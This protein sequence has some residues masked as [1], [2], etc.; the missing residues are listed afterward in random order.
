MRLKSS[1]VLRLNSRLVAWGLREATAWRIGERRANGTGARRGERQES[2]DQ[3]GSEPGYAQLLCFAA[4]ISRSH[5]PRA[6]G[7]DLD[8]GRGRTEPAWHLVPGELDAL[9]SCSYSSDAPES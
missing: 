2:Q 8:G 3:A 4:L 1:Q 6:W 9:H 7:R 5:F